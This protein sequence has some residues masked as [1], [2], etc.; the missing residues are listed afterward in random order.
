VVNLVGKCNLDDELA[1]LDLLLLNSGE[2]LLLIVSVLELDKA[3]ALRAAVALG[4]NVG[5][6]GVEALEDLLQTLVINSEGQVGYEEGGSRLGAGNS[7]GRR[8][9]A[10]NARG[11]R[12]TASSSGSS[13]ASSG[14]TTSTATATAE[15][16]TAT[17]VES[18]GSSA[19][20]NS[21]SGSATS[22][23]ASGGT[24]APEEAAAGST[25]SSSSAASAAT[26]PT[27]EALTASR[28][29]GILAVLCDFNVDLATVELLLVH[30][31]D[32]LVGLSLGG[33][34]HEAVAK[35]TGATSDNVGRENIASARES[36][37]ELALTGL[38]G[39]VADENLESGCGRAS[40]GSGGGSGRS[41]S[42]SSHAN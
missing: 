42:R 36:L 31:S 33:K 6:R 40:S 11:A 27:T 29:G 20:G 5:S 10:L 8:L 21:V 25:A 12:S 1:A 30:Q 19:V 39:Q 32:R 38:E 22:S 7:G 28:S 37:L 14:T 9:S 26:T 13:T 18:T 2:S 17:R 15:A 35:R 24:T 34:L 41:G 4:N 23:S 16:T 3:E